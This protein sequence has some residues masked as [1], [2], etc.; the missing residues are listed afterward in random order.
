MTTSGTSRGAALDQLSV[1]E[2]LRRIDLF[3]ELSEDELGNV[4]R[5]IERQPANDGELLVSEGE[6]SEQLYI[7]ES[8]EVEVFRHVG[9]DDARKEVVLATLGSGKCFG[10]MSLLDDLPPSA[11]VRCKGAC[12][13]LTVGRLD[14][15]VL[16]NWDTILAAKMWRTF[17]RMLS[18]R[19]R[20][21]N[22]SMLSRFVAGDE[23]SKQLLARAEG[24]E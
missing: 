12:E 13:L 4:E 1:R 2:I 14:L 7:L 8:G 21:T 23:Q 11:S 10:E 6:P 19:L 18:R 9:Q 5:C 3:A 20:D 22:D 24:G 15:D 17:A 16:L